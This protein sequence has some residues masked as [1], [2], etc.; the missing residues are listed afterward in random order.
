MG[1]IN[2]QIWSLKR[3]NKNSWKL[4]KHQGKNAVKITVNKGDYQAIGNDGKVT[5]R[6]ELSEKDSAG[7]LFTQVVFGSARK[8]FIAPNKEW[9][10]KWHQALIHYHLHKNGR[11]EARVWIDKKMITDYFGKLGSQQAV[12]NPHFKMGLYRDQTEIPQTIYF[13]NFSRASRK[14]LL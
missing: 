5:E 3:L 12:S 14:E 1:S 10:G 8:R 6:A 7:K 13:A 11:G 9:R 2:R 4:L